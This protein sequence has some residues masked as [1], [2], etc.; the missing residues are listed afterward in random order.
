MK[1]MLCSRIVLIIVFIFCFSSCGK[2]IENKYNNYESAKSE[3]L[4]EKGWI[5]GDL[6]FKSMTDIYQRTDLDINSC[7]FS[8]K[9]SK[10]DVAIVKDKAIKTGTS[11]NIKQLPQIKIPQFWKEKVLKANY[12]V[13]RDSKNKD[14]VFVVI[15]TLQNRIYGWRK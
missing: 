12:C 2:E 4:F 7:I 8:F 11:I 1:Q 10:E 14:S 3:R 13:I 15:D 5:S 9:L 6:V